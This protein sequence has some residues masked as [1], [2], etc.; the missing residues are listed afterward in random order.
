LLA[1]LL[2][3]RPRL[4]PDTELFD[5]LWPQSLPDTT[6]VR[7]L[8]AEIRAALHDHGHYIIRS[9]HGRGHAFGRRFTILDDARPSRCQ[10]IVGECRFDLRQGENVIGRDSTANVQIESPCVSRRHA[11]IAVDDDHATV[12]DLGSRNGTFVRARRTR[13]TTPLA[14]GDLIQFGCAG[15]SFVALPAASDLGAGAYFFSSSAT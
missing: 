3:R 14:D 4:V 12:T 11:I 15:A 6:R 8:V 7:R 2:E 10:L 1:Y 9:V 13:S 5:H